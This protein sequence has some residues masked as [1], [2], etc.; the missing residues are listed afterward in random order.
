[1]QGS[2]E[3]AANLL[4]SSLYVP[5]VARLDLHDLPASHMDGPAYLNVLRILDLPQTIA[6]AME[7]TRIVLY[8]PE[9]EYD[10]FPGKVVEALGL[11]SKAFGVRKSL[12]GD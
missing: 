9:A 4:Y 1:M 8:Q 11:G 7:R 2:G 5:D 10:G 12:P 6:L 3:M